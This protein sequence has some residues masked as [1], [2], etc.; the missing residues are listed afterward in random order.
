MD[1]FYHNAALALGNVKLL[2]CLRSS[3]K[4]L[5]I[6]QILLIFLIISLYQLIE[7]LTLLS[8]RHDQLQQVLNPSP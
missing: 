6:C 8:I 7:N 2:L 3:L 5:L 1:S 4:N